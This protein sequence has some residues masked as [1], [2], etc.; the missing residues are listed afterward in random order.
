MTCDEWYAQNVGPRPVPE[1]FRTAWDAV[2]S[3]V[4]KHPTIRGLGGRQYRTVIHVL[5]ELGDEG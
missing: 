2:L 1:L 3:E 4:R 5:D